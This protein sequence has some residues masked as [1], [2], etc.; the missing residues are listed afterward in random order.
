[1]KSLNHDIFQK[2]ALD[3][4]VKRPDAWYPTSCLIISWI[5]N[6][7]EKHSIN[8]TLKFLLGYSRLLKIWLIHC[9]ATPSCLFSVNSQFPV[10]SSSWFSQRIGW[11]I[12][13]EENKTFLVAFI[14]SYAFAF[15]FIRASFPFSKSGLL[16][17]WVSPS[18]SSV[19]YAPRFPPS[20]EPNNGLIIPKYWNCSLLV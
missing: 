10:H 18:P 3:E 11:K 5:I 2:Q 14:P 16:M 15:M 17:F 13:Q 1:M 8:H 12:C 19:D 20:I 9:Q 7:G 6:I 4:N